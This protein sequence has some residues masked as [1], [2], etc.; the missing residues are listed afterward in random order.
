AETTSVTE[1]IIQASP[2]QDS[3]SIPPES[4]TTSPPSVA[5]TTS[6]TESIIQASPQQELVSTPPELDTSETIPILP[7][8]LDNIAVTT[9]LGNSNPLVQES[10]F[11]TPSSTISSG[12][13]PASIQA[14]P[15]VASNANSTSSN[16][17]I[18]PFIS[19]QLDNSSATK[20]SNPQGVKE[21][22]TKPNFSAD[23]PSS[24]SSISEL[25]GASNVDSVK[26]S[27][28]NQTVQKQTEEVSLQSPVIQKK[29]DNSRNNDNGDNKYSGIT[30]NLVQETLLQMYSSEATETSTDEEEEVVLSSYNSSN[31]SGG[32]ENSQEAQERNL[33]ILAREI[34]SLIRQRL[35]IER[36]RHGW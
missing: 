22:E 17:I 32:E 5:E 12:E 9:P 10:N 35:E 18:K 3:V 31:S 27:S 19:S 20:G 30:S 2:Q 11:I 33:D 8:V 24:W 7:T 29:E 16:S 21:S 13:L 25:L 1:S 4:E 34:Y 14:K 36:E 26:N 6:V 15:E 23:V 28:S